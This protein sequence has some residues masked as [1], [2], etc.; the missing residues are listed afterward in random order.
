MSVKYAF[1]IHSKERGRRRRRRI[2]LFIID[3]STL[4]QLLSWV[5]RLMDVGGTTFP[6][7]KVD[8]KITRRPT[9]YDVCCFYFDCITSGICIID[10]SQYAHYVFKTFKNGHTGTINFEV[11]GPLL[12]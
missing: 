1:Y 9:V 7:R 6:A 4:I 2:F 11:M 8:G 12:P 5:W 10:A 3:P